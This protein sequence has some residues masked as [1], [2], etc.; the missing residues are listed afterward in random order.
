MRDLLYHYTTE[1]G[2]TGIVGSDRIRATHI[3]FLN[4]WTEFRE[5]FT[6][7]YVRRLLDSFRASLPA[8]LPAEAR[9][10]IDGMISRRAAEILEI[11]LA[12]E[13]A[14]E[15]FV[16]SFTSASPQ[17]TGDP[18]DRLSQW[19]GYASATQGFSLGFDKSLLTEA[20]EINNRKARAALEQCVYEDAEKN[21]FFEEIGREAASRFSELRQRGMQVP[22][23][24][25]T[26]RPD[27][28][29]EY[30]SVTY[31]FLESLSRATAKVFTAAAR[32]K[33]VG[34]R[35]EREWRIIFQ[36]AKD[37]LAPVVKYRDGQFGRTPYIE[38]PLGL[39]TPGTSPLRRIV[40]GPGVRKD[41]AKR[42]V[43]SLLV[44]LGIPVSTPGTGTGVEI[45][46][47]LIPYRS[48]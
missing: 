38:I 16:Y 12:S 26:A 28:S 13:S 14:N 5:A 3:R 37:V 15:T 48:E 20:V 10:V 33:N 31:Y 41:D 21:S 44:S 36:A 1:A 2:L 30:K 43:E 32:I 47:S 34:F 25:E 18:G 40:V 23:S 42:M 4:D 22:D 24:F 39:T 11:I 29:E 27:A 19:R 9:L 45:A 6:E 46:A 8:D 17:E 35:E 7:S